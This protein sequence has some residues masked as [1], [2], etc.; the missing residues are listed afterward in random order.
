[1]EVVD[2]QAPTL[3]GD[4][5]TNLVLLVALAVQR[6]E[7]QVA[8]LRVLQKGA[9]H[10]RQRWGLV[11]LS[12]EPTQAP[13][14]SRQ[15][16][17]RADARTGG[18][19]GERPGKMRLAHPARELQPVRRLERVLDVGRDQRAGRARPL[20]DGQ[21]AAVVEEHVERFIVVLAEAQDTGLNVIPGRVQA[22]GFLASHIGGGAL[23]GG[24]DGK[25]SGAP[26]RS[27]RF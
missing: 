1:M 10:G 9:A 5:E 11:V 21:I 12:P 27:A 19:L 4:R 6:Q 2:V 7:P 24:A 18:I 8:V 14:Y 20:I 22:Q 3:H 15:P 25:S 13:A 16:D 26:S 23:I 17:G